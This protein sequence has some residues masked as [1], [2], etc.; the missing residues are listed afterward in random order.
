MLKNY[1]GFQDE[2]S[3]AETR[4]QEALAREVERTVRMETGLRSDQTDAHPEDSRQGE[5]SHEADEPEMH[6]CRNPSVEATAPQEEGSTVSAQRRSRGSEETPE[7]EPPTRRR[8]TDGNRRREREI[9]AEEDYPQRRRQRLEMLELEEPFTFEY[10]GSSVSSSA[11]KV[12]VEQKETMPSKLSQ[13][14]YDCQYQLY[15]CASSW[16]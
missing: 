15:H 10:L 11:G 2:L 7:E 4:L 9:E 3:R 6:D 12:S 13:H 8:R 1:E 16:K 5:P 14:N